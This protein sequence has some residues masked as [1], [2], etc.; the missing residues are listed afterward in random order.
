M[1]L[2]ERIKSL[3]P[4]KR[5]LLEKKLKQKLSKK[6]HLIAI[7]RDDNRD[8]FPL[9]FAQQRLWFL[10]QLDPESPFYNIPT[11]LRLSG[12]LDTQALKS[13]IND[14][15]KRHEALRTAFISEGKEAVQ[16]IYP[17]LSIDLPIEDLTQLKDEEQETAIKHL[18]DEEVRKPF[19]LDQLPLLRCKLLRLKDTE[20]ILIINIHHVVSDGWSMSV[21]N[22]ELKAFYAHHAAH[23]PVT[24]DDLPVQYCDFSVWQREWMSGDVLDEQLGYWTEELRDA[25]PLLEMP[26]DRAYP[27]AKSYRGKRIRYMLSANLT[28][29]LKQQAKQNNATLFMFLF[30]AFN[31]LLSK[32]T[33]QQD[34]VVGS[35]IAS[36]TRQEIEPLIGFF[37]NT[38]ALR[39]DLSGNPTFRELL[40]RVRETTLGAYDHQG[41]PFEKIVEELKPERSL[42]Y[43]P[44]FQVAFA[45]QSASTKTM[46]LEGID[47][48]PVEINSGVEKFDLTISAEETSE[49]LRLLWSYNTDIYNQDTIERMAGHYQALL[50]QIVKHPDK[51]I[52]EY[53]LLTSEERQQ[54]LVDWN[55]TATDCPRDQC[56]LQLFETQVAHSPDA[57]AVVY[58]D[59]SLSYADLNARANRLAHY[60]IE[61]GVGPDTLVALCLE[62]SLDLIVTVLGIL[63]AGGAYVPLDPGY[64]KDRLAFMLEDTQAPVLITQ[65]S[66]Q[67]T[68]P[69]H[70]ATVLCLDNAVDPLATFAEANPALRTQPHHLAYIIYTSGSTGQPKGV[71]ICHRSL[72]NLVTWHQRTYELSTQ[73]RTTLL[74][75]P[76]FDA[77]VWEIWPTLTAGASLYVPNEDIRMAPDRLISWYADKGITLS[78]LPTPL[79]TALLEQDMSA[80]LSL[81]TLLTGG[82]ALQLPSTKPL[83]FKLVNHY[84]PTE[85]TVVTTAATVIPEQSD[86][87]P[88][89]GRPI[90]N[91]QVYIL[92]D[93]LKPVPTGVVGEL[94]IGGDGLARGYLNRPELTAER[95]IPNPLAGTPGERLYK[96][97]DLVRYLADGNIEFMG[98]SDDQVKIRGFRIELGEIEATLSQHPQVQDSLVMVREE[99]ARGKHLVAYVVTEQ[100]VEDVITTIQG[101]LKETLPEYMVPSAFVTLDTF[102]LTP[103]GKVDKQAL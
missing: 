63:K 44:L 37:V 21:F 51:P 8:S 15:I 93:H 98:R 89:I 34:I 46:Q 42:S 82:E 27:P 62:R 79:A 80:R 29:S 86:R 6:N 38:L 41:L 74:A 1:S 16:K 59:Q 7:P 12:L 9:S 85:S 67:A 14:I 24:L 25:S 91:T 73:D 95:F 23:V 60:L 66:L 10:Y 84:G 40:A 32:Y 55:A 45:L 92:D 72:I 4:E 26:L 77:S 94:Y 58:Q 57:V 47:I 75:G 56:I 53:E 18:S 50:E 96:T 87:S 28:E 43:S 3:P 70:G 100:A 5:A 20:H 52:S 49:G 31:L 65:S 64:P 90:S 81:R 103:N 68:L 2:E 11:S 101:Y 39:T 102:P 33:R 78:F 48:Q 83:P 35:P 54:L 13:S 88:P 36:R 30:A 69:P 76:A 22:K 17:D 71:E 97:G 61:Q 99:G 19:N